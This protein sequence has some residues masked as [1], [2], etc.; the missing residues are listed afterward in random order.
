MMKLI[1]AYLLCFAGCL[2]AMEKSE[3]V[4]VLLSN[5]SETSATIK[6][7]LIRIKADHPEL[8]EKLPFLYSLLNK[9]GEN[10][11]YMSR[12]ST[13]T[14]AR[15][16]SIIN[17]SIKP[18]EMAQ[19]TN[20]KTLRSQAVISVESLQ[21][22]LKEWNL[23]QSIKTFR[24]LVNPYKVYT[25]TLTRL[26]KQ[27]D[28][29]EVSQMKHTEIKSVLDELSELRRL[30]QQDPSF[31]AA[32]KE[33]TAFAATVY[34]EFKNALALNKFGDFLNPQ[35]AIEALRKAIGICYAGLVVNNYRRQTD[36]DTLLDSATKNQDIEDTLILLIAGAT[37]NSESEGV[38][39]FGDLNTLK[40]YK[41]LNEQREN[42]NCILY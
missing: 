23:E 36:L 15:I 14:V 24:G 20:S 40:Q 1:L 29:A 41:V 22:S 31:D 33:N 8:K 27:L 10:T 25:E 37:V 12:L 18:L 30:W 39:N 26:S 19:Q 5:D 4:P 34:K 35:D 7:L 17:S 2:M 9:I 32:L 13:E 6:G 28:N 42:K 3:P 21:I 38:E 16:Y 11:T